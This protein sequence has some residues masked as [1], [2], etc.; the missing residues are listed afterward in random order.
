MIDPFL[1]GEKWFCAKYKDKNTRRVLYINFIKD[2]SATAHPRFQRDME[3]L[4]RFL[5]QPMRV[6]V[7]LPVV[8]SDLFRSKDNP[9]NLVINAEIAV[10]DAPPVRWNSRLQKLFIARIA[11]SNLEEYFDH[12]HGICPNFEP[13]ERF[14]VLK[15]TDY[16]EPGLPTGSLRGCP[17]TVSVLGGTRLCVIVPHVKE[18]IRFNISGR[19][20]EIY[21]GFYHRHLVELPFKLE[22]HIQCQFL[23]IR[24]IMGLIA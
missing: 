2:K 19:K 10:K 20:L 15:D 9:R 22:F 7:P 1:D 13:E 3:I 18:L 4:K 14:E 23:G 21:D 8:N 12:D 17:L 16:V 11:H 5:P 6:C 24:A